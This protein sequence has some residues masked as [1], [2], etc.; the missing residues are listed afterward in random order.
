MIRLTTALLLVA[1][2]ARAQ[3]FETAVTADMFVSMKEAAAAQGV[4]FNWSIQ[5][6]SADQEKVL[7]ILKGSGYMVDPGAEWL[8]SAKDFSLYSWAAAP[9]EVGYLVLPK[10]TG[11]EPVTYAPLKFKIDKPDSTNMV[12]AG[13]TADEIASRILDGMRKSIVMVCQIGAQP[14]TITGKAS[15]AGI[16]EIEATWRGSEICDAVQ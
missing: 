8:S 9:G 7:G 2:A 16:V 5:E 3:D 11:A 6:P 15:A 4:E 10:A 13:Y 14:E 1:S 12:A